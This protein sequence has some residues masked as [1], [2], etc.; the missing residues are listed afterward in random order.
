MKSTPVR[1]L[2]LLLATHSGV[3]LAA[4]QQLAS[5]SSAEAER[6]AVAARAVE[7]QPDVLP[8]GALADLGPA[9][10]YGLGFV[11]GELHGV[12][13]GFQ[14]RFDAGGFHM[15]PRVSGP[16]KDR[17]LEFELVA[18][19][20]G[21]ELRSIARHDVSAPE[22]RMDRA[23]FA[24]GPGVEARYDVGETAIEQSFLFRTPQP[25]EG[26]LVVRGR[27]STPLLCEPGEAG[28]EG[29]SFR[30]P[31]GGEIHVGAVWGIDA[32]DRK[33]QGRLRFDGRHLDLILPAAFVDEA[34]YPLLLDPLVGPSNFTFPVQ[35]WLEPEAPDLAFDESTQRYLAVW[36]Q[37]AYFFAN[38]FDVYGQF[39]SPYGGPI[40]NVIPIDTTSAITSFA[41][42]GNVNATNQ[43]LVAY[44][45]G[46]GIHARTVS[47]TTAAVSARQSVVD[48]LESPTGV[49]LKVGGEA[50]PPYDTALVAWIEDGSRVRFV[51]L[52]CPSSSIPLPIEFPK[53]VSHIPLGQYSQLSMTRSGGAAGYWMLAWQR[54]TY[55]DRDVVGALVS[56]SGS[57]SLGPQSLFTGPD[58]QQYPAVAGDGDRFAVVCS[59]PYEVSARPFSRSGITPIVS[60][61][62]VV[63]ST[64][65]F[66]HQDKELELVDDAYV[67]TWR[68]GGFQGS[69]DHHRVDARALDRWTCLPIE[70]V[71]TVSTFLEPKKPT[72]HRIF[73][74][75]S[76]TTSSGVP[77]RAV[78][79]LSTTGSFYDDNQLYATPIQTP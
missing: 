43:F 74:E 56:W 5:L 45:G 38:D 47:A 65:D 35:S 20:R 77:N 44:Y 30:D 59:T 23:R 41:E 51:H 28:P 63:V 14:V 12:A 15:A 9:R 68:I 72:F 32:E 53:T 1:S 62:E 7:L 50:L 48:D 33:V 69:N 25:G 57:H 78:V 24:V 76:A 36:H 66:V 22:R 17:T 13:P 11:D 18:I 54:N 10:P 70:P 8:P 55:G 73:A 39:R 64:E 31:G 61:P 71:Y 49:N 79:C 67:V 16:W 6:A 26:D 46:G 52:R 3:V 40:G 4:Q 42:V 29:L 2:V 34:A 27:I 75:S 19:G 58:V 37:R 21:S 60:G